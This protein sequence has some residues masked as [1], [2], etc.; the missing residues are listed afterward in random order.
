MEKILGHFFIPHS[1]FYLSPLLAFGDFLE[2]R[3]E[4]RQLGGVQTELGTEGAKWGD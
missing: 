2:L 3:V 1:Y 4:L